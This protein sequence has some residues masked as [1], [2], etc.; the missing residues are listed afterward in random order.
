MGYDRC[1]QLRSDAFQMCQ[2]QNQIKFN[3]IV[4]VGSS[5]IISRARG[6]WVNTWRP[7]RIGT[8]K[9]WFLWREEN[10]SSRRKPSEQ[11]REPATNSTHIWHR[12]RES[13][14]GHIG[15]RRVLSPLRHPCSLPHCVM[16]YKKEEPTSFVLK[17]EEPTTMDFH[18]EKC[19]TREIKCE[20][21]WRRQTHRNREQGSKPASKM[22]WTVYWRR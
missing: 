4:H 7:G 3:V 10:R 5:R 2:N 19:K 16:S 14:P 18:T 12:D 13:N 11:G 8:W 20:V 22:G 21:G 15:G 17:N 6:S 1:W 9:C